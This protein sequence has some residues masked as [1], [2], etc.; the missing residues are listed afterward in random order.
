MRIQ[1]EKKINAKANLLVIPVFTE[2]LQKTKLEIP[3]AL[4]SFLDKRVKNKEFSGKSGEVISGYLEEKT[5]PGKFIF[6][7]C[8]A[9]KNFSAKNSRILG[10]KLAQ[11]V[12]GT[13]SK[14]ANLL[15]NEGLSQFLEEFLEGF[16]L[17]QYR[18]DK[19]K[20]D[21]KKEAN[22]NLETFE[23]IAEKNSHSQVELKLKKARLLTEAVNYVKHLINS[24]SNVV[25]GQYLADDAKE[26]AKENR[27]KLAVF[28]RKELTKLGCGGILSV[29]QGSI[30]EP[31]LVVLQ[32]EGAKNKKEKPIVIVGKGVIFD[33]GGYNLKPTN[34]IETMHQDMA[35][36]ATVLGLFSILKKL[37]I[38][39]NVI[40]ITPIAENLVSASAYRPSDIIK[41]LNGKTVEVTNTD[42]EGRLILADAIT[43]GT[44]FNPEAIVTIA[45][46]TG[47]VSIALGDRYAGLIGNNI[48]LRSSIQ[49]AGREVDELGWPLPLHKDFKKKMNSEVA[50]MRN[51]DI[52]SSRMAGSS[53]GAA[54]LERFV[55]KYPWCHIDIGGTAFTSD[56]LE[57]QCKGATAHGLRMLVKFLEKEQ[58]RKGVRQ[59]YSADLR[60]PAVLYVGG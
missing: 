57:Y 58:G 50:D 15:L 24:P 17:K 53:K 5:L 40:G 44:R 26:I 54:F 1:I 35:G 41:M 16:F 43:Y 42:A 10:A 3:Q 30:N 23:I 14:H 55:E 31:K 56:P 9:V 32:Y 51:C 13:K 12:H 11:H 38:Q 25:H 18:F 45:T 7:G 37:G 6:L 46:L 36:A 39:K 49:K 19:F 20:T 4:K 48:R 8:G 22:N 33:T 21:L 60:H 29:N 52:G 59:I 47:A 27:Y 2:D 28:G 34:G